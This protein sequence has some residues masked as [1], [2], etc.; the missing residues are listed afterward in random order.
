[1]AGAHHLF[2][3]SSWEMQSWAT[4]GSLPLLGC[5][6]GLASPAKSFSI[7]CTLCAE[8]WLPHSHPHHTGLQHSRGGY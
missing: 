3:R 7:T 6:P 2:L 1:M 4:L 8:P 5:C